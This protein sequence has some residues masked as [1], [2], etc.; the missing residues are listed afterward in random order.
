MAL[1]SAD[2]WLR[3][4]MRAEHDGE[5]FRAYD[6]ARNG[7]A[8]YPHDAALGYRAVLALARSGA[9]AKAQALLR[10]LGLSGRTDR[11]FPALE[12]RL[13]RDLAL[14]APAGPERIRLLLDAAG[15]YRELFAR[16]GDYYPGIN[17]A[18]LLLLA[19]QPGP[20]AEIAARIAAQ[21]ED[22]KAEVDH[23]ELFWMLASLAEAH[24][25]HG[26]LERAAAA[27][28]AARIA[29]GDNLAWLSSAHR[30]I[31]RAAGAKGVS[32]DWL[33]PVSP[34]MVIHYTGH[35]IAGWRGAGGMEAMLEERLRAEIAGLLD[36]HAVGFGYG[37]LAAGADIL[38]AEALLARGAQLHVLLP[39]GLEDFVAQSVHPSGGA[40]IARFESCLGRAKSVRYATDGEYL[41]DTSLF[42]YASRVA[43]GLA[44]LTSQHLSA[45]IAQMA[46]WDGGPARGLAGTEIDVTTWR[47]TGRP[48]TII[49]VEPGPGDTA[50]PQPSPSAGS[51]RRARAMLFGDLQGFSRLA[52]REVPGFVAGVL[53][54]VERVCDRHRASLLLANTWGDGLFLV[55]RRAS[56]AAACALDLQDA[57]G[58]LDFAA[59]GLDAALSLRVGGH[60]GPVFELYDPVLQRRNFFGAHVSRAARIEPVT[61]PAMVYVTETFAAVLALEHSDRFACD[62]VGMTAAAKGA[63][64]MR[65]FALRHRAEAPQGELFPAAM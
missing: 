39:F 47:N 24:V 31:R 50:P 55:F 59:L 46:V 26:A 53:D 60:L 38:F 32:L 9:A 10:E 64:T 42:A 40:W 19:G 21:L 14:A 49:P 44:V 20:A 8:A 7:L 35:I 27:A 41:G 52:D 54:A 2:A 17:L 37:S 23:G 16:T 22:R 65:M 28:A 62:Y 61:P 13:E 3:E 33:R 25:I 58:S 15:R 36:E 48:Q 6:V 30:S 57:L 18:N 45:P 51:P 43:M 11:D 4:A 5:F 29:S 1:R 34:P 12:A 63:G 56:E